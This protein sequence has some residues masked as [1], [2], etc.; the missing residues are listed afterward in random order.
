MDRCAACPGTDNLKAF[1]DQL[2]KEEPDEINYKKWT[3]TDGSKLES[4]TEDK[5]D[6]LESL[7]ILISNL[8]KHYYI[9][10]AQSAFFVKCKE[11]ITQ[12]SCVLIS[13]FSENFSFII[14]DCVQGYYWMNQQAT[15]L[16]F[17][18]YLKNKEGEICSASMCVISDHLTHDSGAVNTYLKPVLNHI[19]SINPF[20]KN[21]KYFTDGS[22]AQYKN[23]KNFANLCAHEQ[24]F[25]LKAEWHFFASCHGNSACDGI[26]G[27][28]KRLARLASLQRPLS[29]QITTP[30]Q[31]F[32]WAKDNVDIMMFYVEK[33]LVELNSVEIERR[34]ADALPIKGTRSFHCYVPLN[35]YQLK[36]SALSCDTDFQIFNVLPEPRNSFDF[37]SCLVKDFIACVS[38][39]DGLW[40]FAQ[41]ISTDPENEEYLV[42]FLAPDGEAGFL[43]GYK[44]KNVNARVE[45][46]VVLCKVISLHS[47]SKRSRMLKVNQDEFTKITEKC[48]RY[49]A[50]GE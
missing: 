16:P 33:Q 13:D 36:V 8:T 9:A 23:K 14:Q 11:E 42:K 27:T 10:R 38:Q 22:S 39:D 41:I 18:A 44:F 4:I 17:L 37:T 7:V 15:V 20:I 25:G 19:K 29:D 3:Q 31:L 48:T 21:V 47:T 50:N 30:I 49:M 26:G 43:K 32:E 24:S 2:T 5:D 34:M 1:L 28:I 6:F 40:H 45:V 12:E 46:S 35:A